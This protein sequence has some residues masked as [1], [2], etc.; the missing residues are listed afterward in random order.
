M[1]DDINAGGIQKISQVLGKRNL[2]VAAAYKT[3]SRE[4]IGVIT[5]F[6]PIDLMAKERKKMFDSRNTDPDRTETRKTAVEHT[7]NI[8]Q[9]RWN[10]SL[11]GRS[12]H[13]LIPNILTFC[14]RKH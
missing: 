13:R 6:P 10:M 5:G 12:T 9:E 4:A 7:F 14:S 3:V 8:W 2:R 11:K 1:G